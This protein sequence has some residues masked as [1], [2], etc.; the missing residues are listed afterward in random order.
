MQQF[1]SRDLMVATLPDGSEEW[2]AEACDDCSNCTNDTSTQK[3]RPKPKPNWKAEA[4]D[5]TALREQLKS[6]RG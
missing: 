2:G 5:L 1:A 6:A 3:P 4:D